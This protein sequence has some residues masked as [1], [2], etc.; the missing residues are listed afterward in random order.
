MELQS[1]HFVI[2]GV[3]LMFNRVLLS[4]LLRIHCISQ[5][6][7]SICH[8]V[9]VSTVKHLPINAPP[10]RTRPHARSFLTFLAISQ[11]KMARFSF[12]KKLLEGKHVLF[13]AIKLANAHGRLLGVLRYISLEDKI[14]DHIDL[15][16]SLFRSHNFTRVLVI[17][18]PDRY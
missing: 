2:S 1:F 3:D 9:E 13:K 6:C 7:L 16:K 5:S 18:S 14:Y 10:P 12:R 11:P 4:T 17:K 15:P 8:L